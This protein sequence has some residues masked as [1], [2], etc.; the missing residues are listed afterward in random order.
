M[1]ILILGG[2]GRNGRLIIQAA[3]A[4]D[5]SVTALV[6]DPDSLPSALAAHARLTIVRGT[7]TSQSDI[8]AALRTPAAPQ[9]VISSLS[10][11]RTS[12]SPWAPLAPDSPANLMSL[13][14]SALVCA[15]RDAASDPPPK[16]VVNS[17]LGVGA[18]FDAMLLPLRLIFRHTTMRI[19]LRDH[20]RVDDIVRKSGL[21]F[22]LPRPAAL[23]NSDADCPVK[24]WPDNGRGMPWLGALTR[25]SLAEW[26]VD[27]AEK[28]DW[29]GRA[30]VLTN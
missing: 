15:L 16:L 14:I 25:E 3:L 13:S 26:M 17:S 6:R 11:R 10:I 27:A 5:H 9:A 21:P 8:E 1:H 23:R 22:V 20:E 4:R 30:P 12:D 28:T 18:S 29:D 2:S 7:P 24:V 19:G